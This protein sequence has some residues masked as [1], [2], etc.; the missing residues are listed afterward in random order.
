MPDVL[1]LARPPVSH[2]S[3]NPSLTHTYFITISPSVLVISS[4]I[5]PIS[6]IR[7]DDRRK[8]NYLI[9]ENHQKYIL[10]IC[11]L[12][13]T[14]WMY[15]LECGM[16]SHSRFPSKD[17]EAEKFMG[18]QDRLTSDGEGKS[19]ET[20]LSVSPAPLSLSLN[21]APILL[22]WAREEEMKC[23][24]NGWAMDFQ[25]TIKLLSWFNSI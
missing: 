14:I 4:G 5:V 23:V 25:L 7:L 3:P 6:S 20:K 12:L 18:R 11:Y 13:N 17:P 8:M 2:S 9:N 1:G 16:F 21:C 22:Q 15:V 19:D 10:A 24:M